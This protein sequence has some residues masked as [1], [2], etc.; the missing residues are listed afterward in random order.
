MK[1]NLKGRH[2]YIAETL[3]FPSVHIVIEKRKPEI[4]GVVTGRF[5]RRL[6]G[7]GRAVGIKFRPGMF[8]PW[9]GGSLSSLTDR[10]VSLNSVF[11][12]AGLAL[13]R[14]ILKEPEADRCIE[15]AESFLTERVP[16][17]KSRVEEIR[18]TVERVIGDRRI[19][20][21]QQVA[22]LMGL[23]L[24][25]VQRLFRKYVGVSPKWI[26]RRYRLHEAAETLAKGKVQKLS[27]LAL[28]LGYFDQAHFIRDFK[29]VVGVAPGAYLAKET[30]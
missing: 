29:S 26:I 11:G 5:A 23:G 15:I 1:W 20:R 28:R 10:V 13:R 12:N 9:Y 18:D 22:D 3:P 30:G 27:E 14:G 24:R 25:P 16:R 8:Y 2:P 4:Y 17:A 19:V 7:E 6:Q 21:A